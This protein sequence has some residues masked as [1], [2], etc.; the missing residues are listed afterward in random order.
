MMTCDQSREL[1]VE[2]L[3]DELATDVRHQFDE[4]LVSCQ[5][6][7]AMYREMET[8]LRILNRRPRTEPGQS[9][10]QNFWERLKP[11]ISAEISDG[12]KV[13]P[14]LIRARPAFLWG[15]A[16]LPSWAYGIA[17]MLLIAVGIYLGRTAFNRVEPARPEPGANN[18]AITTPVSANDSTSAEALAYLERSKNL[19]IGIANLHAEQHSS[20]DLSR[21]QTVSRQLLAQ[22]NIL[23]VSLNKPD[24]QQ[25][26]QLIFDL[27]VVLLQLANIEVKPG[28]PAVEL[29]KKG[30]DQKS[31]L[32]KI[33]LEQMR[34][35]TR[36]TPAVLE[37]KTRSNL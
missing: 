30:I 12:E 34:A 25:L 32:L 2:A 23:K 21:Q 29:V 20:L 6:C 4:H 17:A 36:R 19:L 15:P 14:R 37:K 9:F 18:A 27:E 28:V 24:Q 26:R 13:S 3:Y 22:A 5:E 8:T 33:N 35:V 7:S 16:R 31:I 10:M 1:F 11:Q